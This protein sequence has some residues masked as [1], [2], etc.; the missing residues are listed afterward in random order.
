MIK[1]VIFDMD[2]LMLETEYLQS[3]ASE[4]VLIEYGKKPVLNK[5]GVVQPVGLNARKIWKLFKKKY[6]ID[7]DVEVLL[8]K[9]NKVYIKLLKKKVVAKPGLYKLI[10]LLINHNIKIAVA[11][12][13]V[14][15]HIEFVVDKLKIKQYF[16]ALISG[17]DFKRGKPYPDIF[18]KTAEDLDIKPREC[19]VLEDAETG[20]VAGKSAGMKVIAVPNKYTKSHNFLKA[21]LI[22]NSL[23]EINWSTISNI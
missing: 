4:T 9:K 10:K 14:F 17:E 19:V 22:V 2:G 7:E 1:A 3:K 13:S 15:E 12:S 21:D 18:L 20:V 6:D 5:D 8:D 23:E 11:S 16:H